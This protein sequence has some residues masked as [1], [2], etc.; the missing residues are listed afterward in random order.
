MGS[1]LA[2]S[3]LYC[4]EP[5][6]I[7]STMRKGV[8]LAIGIVVAAFEMGLWCGCQ[9]TKTAIKAPI[10]TTKIPVTKSKVRAA[11][12]GDLVEPQALVRHDAPAVLVTQVTPTPAPSKSPAANPTPGS[13]Y[14]WRRQDKDEILQRVDKLTAD[15][16]ER[17]CFLL[18][19]VPSDEVF[20]KI[21]FKGRLKRCINDMYFNGQLSDVEAAFLE[22][23]RKPRSQ[24]GDFSPRGQERKE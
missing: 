16:A 6:I 8:L 7:L 10:A 5:G 12:T 21:N 23:Q 3:V 24:P 17:L 11:K 4:L 18:Q 22:L 15:D 13:N 9:S 1:A 2:S 19:L 20:D 14:A